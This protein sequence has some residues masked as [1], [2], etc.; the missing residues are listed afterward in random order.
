MFKKL[1]IANRGEIACRIIETARRLGVATVAV[2]SEVDTNARHVRMANEALY[3]GPSP[4]AQSYLRG[5]LILEVAQQ[6]GAEAIHPGYGFLSENSAFAQACATAGIVFV[7]PRPD[8]IRDMGLKDR[9]KAIAIEVGA[10][11]LPGYWGQDQSEERLIAEAQKLGFPLLIKAV[12]GGG[13]RGI[14][15]VAALDDLLPALVSAKREA[16]ASFGDDAVML[17]HLVQRPRHLEVQIFGDQHGNLVHMF[18]RDCSIQRRRQKLVEEAP[19][20]GMS[21]EVRESLTQAALKIAKAVNYSNAGTIEFVA[22][23]AGPLR[24]DGFWFLEMNTRLQVEHPVTEAITGLDLVE[25]QLRVAAGERLPLSQSEI[26]MTGAA[27][28]ARIVAEDPTKDF[29]PS[30]GLISG[31]PPVSDLRVDSGF[32]LGDIFPDAYDSLLEKVI[33]HGVDR[34]AAIEALRRHLESRVIT[35]ITTNNGYLAR[36]CGQ[37][38]FIS[39]GVHTGLLADEAQALMKLPAST[40]RLAGLAAIGVQL[41]RE[42]QAQSTI[43]AFGACDGWRLNAPPSLAIAFDLEAVP[44]L[45]TLQSDQTQISARVEGDHAIVVRRHVH[46]QPN[47]AGW[48]VT[49]SYADHAAT[50][51][52]DGHGAYVI[53]AGEAW[54]YPFARATSDIDAHDAGDELKAN[55]PGKIVSVTSQSGQAIK[56]GEVLIVLEAMKM[57][58]SLAAPRDGVIAEMLVAIGRQVR[59]GEI[60]LRLAPQTDVDI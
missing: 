20:P 35:G 50:I 23:G 48:S 25:W 59:A 58:H 39:G 32:D 30:S 49:L 51:L 53:E 5:D 45:A 43:S 31:L 56:K 42:A 33:A 14:R 34:N 41:V 16:A 4:A 37:Q 17:E 36:L 6:T 21:E 9:A 2:Y 27:I 44:L 18:E 12:A 57:E 26:K 11:V 19:A 7:G 47:G 1:L 40:P 55:L 29:L 54:R 38:S 10:P 46:L 22:D 60:L 52:V 24:P 15:A 13:G 8:A 28:E 3:L